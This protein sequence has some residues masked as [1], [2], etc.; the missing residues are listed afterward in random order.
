MSVGEQ[1]RLLGELKSQAFP[2][3]ATKAA[4]V[5]EKKLGAA[6]ICSRCEKSLARHCALRCSLSQNLLKPKGLARAFAFS[7]LGFFAHALCRIGEQPEA[8]RPYPTQL[9]QPLSHFLLLN[10]P[11]P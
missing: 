2:T 8:L 6:S 11:Q 4:F 10:L 9:S 5:R 3:E 1:P 7:R